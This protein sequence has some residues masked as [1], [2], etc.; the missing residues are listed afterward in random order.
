MVVLSK[1]LYKTIASQIY[2][3]YKNCVMMVLV[4]NMYAEGP[5]Y[6]FQL[7]KMFII[8]K[9]NNPFKTCHGSDLFPFYVQLEMN[10]YIEMY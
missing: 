7:W 10:D 3:H 5:H 4:L 2:R 8:L 6:T 1:N 9:Y